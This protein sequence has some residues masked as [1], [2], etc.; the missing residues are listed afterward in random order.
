M[1]RQKKAPLG[2]L[3]SPQ[4]GG[5]IA[6]SFLQ[7]NRKSLNTKLVMGSSLSSLLSIVTTMIR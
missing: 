7:K 2:A 3:K 6:L 1:A 4:G 5:L